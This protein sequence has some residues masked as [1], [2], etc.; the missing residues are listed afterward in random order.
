VTLSWEEHAGEDP[1]T[2]EQDPEQR[3]KLY[4]LCDC[5]NCAGTGKNPKK[6]GGTKCPECRGE[7]R[8]REL[9]AT[10]SEKNLG[11]TIITLGGE[12]TWADC[13]FGL[14]DTMGEVNKKWLVRPW[15]PSARNISDAGRQLSRARVGK[16]K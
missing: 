2:G 14:L 10:C 6:A 4:R 5:I 1:R 9:A 7:G 8:L 13:P 3:F 12:G 11:G 15:L 16:A